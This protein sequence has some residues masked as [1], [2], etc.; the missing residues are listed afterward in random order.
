[1]PLDKQKISSY[2]FNMRRKKGTLIPI[3]ISILETGIELAMRRTAQFHGFMLAK[4][5]QERDEAKLLTAHGTLYKALDRMEKAG[6]LESVW[7]DPLVAARESRP[8]RRFYWVTPA[9]QAALVKALEQQ[10]AD[11]PVEQRPGLA[12][13]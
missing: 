13:S 10:P 2:S 11:A 1:M 9:G 8:R 4:E 6:Y 12:T 5:M 7:E 3:E